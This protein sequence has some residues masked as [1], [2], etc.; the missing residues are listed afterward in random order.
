MLTVTEF[1]IGFQKLKPQVITYRNYKNFNND[2]FQAAIK[3]CGFDPNNTSS[4]KETILSN[5]NKYGPIEKKCIR[6]NE[7]PFMTKNL[8][9]EIMK[10]SRLRNKYLKFKSL[11]DRTK[12]SIQR[13][14][15]EKLLRI[16]KKKYFNKL[17]TKK[18]NDNKTFCRTV[19][20]TFSKKIQKV[21]KLS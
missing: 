9:K 21:I 20:P 6:A 13:N 18:V 12:Y 4:F 16:T 14:F 5:F 2:R 1:K 19:V 11:T 17:D 8:H 7:A 10:R 3:T 15:C